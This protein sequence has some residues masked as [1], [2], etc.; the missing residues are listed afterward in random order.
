MKIRTDETSIHS[1]VS[2]WYVEWNHHSEEHGDTR[3][4]LQHVNI[5]K[6]NECERVTTNGEKKECKSWWVTAIHRFEL[7]LFQFVLVHCV[8]SE[9]WW[10]RKLAGCWPFWGN[11]QFYGIDLLKRIDESISSVGRRGTTRVSGYAIKIA[12]VEFFGGRLVFPLG[13]RGQEFCPLPRTQGSSILL[14]TP[15]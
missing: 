13:I 15:P 6:M 3:K 14:Y 10:S 1:T 2:W 9:Y 7:W 4:I 5:R 8:Y 11:E 12:R